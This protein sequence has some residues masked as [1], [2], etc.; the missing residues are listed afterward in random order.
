M[1]LLLWTAAFLLGIGFFT[2][3]MYGRLF[4][5]FR[6]R[7][8]DGRDY[9]LKTL[10]PRIKNTLVYAFGQKKFFSADQPA[11]I[12]HAVIFWGFLTLSLQVITMFGRGWD[13]EFRIPG[14][15]MHCLGGPYGLLKD[16]FEVAVALG[17]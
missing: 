2:Y 13:P 6:M 3:Q 17:V 4:V 10:I 9:G 8:D 15:S 1:T 11:G 5:L 12:M 14:F 16:F 7:K